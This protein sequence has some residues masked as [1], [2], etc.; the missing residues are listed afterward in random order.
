MSTFSVDMFTAIINGVWKTTTLPP[1][2]V[3]CVERWVHSY[4]SYLVLSPHSTWFPQPMMNQPLPTRF[5]HVAIWRLNRQP[6]IGRKSKYRMVRA[7]DACR[8]ACSHLLI[9]LGTKGLKSICPFCSVAL[10]ETKPFVRLIFQDSIHRQW[11]TI[12]QCRKFYFFY[13]LSLSSMCVYVSYFHYF[14][15]MMIACAHCI[16]IKDNTM[17][18]RVAADSSKITFVLVSPREMWKR[19]R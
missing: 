18:L 4:R 17:S 3:H 15:W 14:T 12:N 11:P 16:E 2:S 8:D 13:H 6:R 19:S 9:F 5:T 7:R 10:A 1:E